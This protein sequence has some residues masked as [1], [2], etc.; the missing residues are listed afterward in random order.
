MDLDIDKEGKIFC[1]LERYS[2]LRQFIYQKKFFLDQ[3]PK[4]F[5]DE[6]QK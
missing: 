6:L 1:F 5:K 3:I 4:Y 2:G